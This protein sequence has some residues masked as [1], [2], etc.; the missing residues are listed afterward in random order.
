MRNSEPAR[1]IFANIDLDSLNRRVPAVKK[2]DVTPA[3]RPVT[4]GS[5]KDISVAQQTVRTVLGI[6]S[7]RAESSSDEEY[8]PR[9]PDNMIPASI[10][11]SSDSEEERSSKKKKKKE[12]KKKSKK[13][14]KK[15]SHHRSRSR[16]RS[17]DDYKHKKRKRSYS[18]SSG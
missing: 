7:E 10:V 18:S 1:G 5:S 16:S 12:K 11:I 8:G 17:R 9:L 6:R 13:K 4:K 15:I 3:E 2:N 14:K